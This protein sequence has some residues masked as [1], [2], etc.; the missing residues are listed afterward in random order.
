MTRINYRNGILAVLFTTTTT[1]GEM[2]KPRNGDARGNLAEHDRHAGIEE[3]TLGLLSFKSRCAG[4]NVD[5]FPGSCNAIE[6]GQDEIRKSN[7]ITAKSNIVTTC[8]DYYNNCPNWARGGLCY[9]SRD[10]MHEE[11]PLSCNVCPSNDED[12]PLPSWHYGLGEDVGVPQELDFEDAG[13]S[14][15]AILWVI[16]QARVYLK[17]HEEQL[18]DTDRCTN[19]HPKCTFW[20]LTDECQNDEDCKFCHFIRSLSLIKH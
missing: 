2:A 11:C 8:E 20:A 13:A 4:T 3:D 5:D 1:R 18:Y 12:G 10:F 19:E 17:D 16:E 9:D 7:N 15:E 14:E 6:T